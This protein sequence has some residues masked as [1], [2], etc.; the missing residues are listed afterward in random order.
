MKLAVIPARGGSKRIPAKNIRSFCGRPVIAYSIAAAAACGL[1]D[2]IVVSTDDERIAAVA[3]RHGAEVP[4]LRPKELAD[5]TTGTN[6]VVKHAIS[7]FAAGGH[8]VTHACCIYATAPFLQA[9]QLLAGFD[10][11]TASGKAFAFSVAL[12]PHPIQRAL[13]V[14]ADGTLGAFYPEH[15]F[16]RSQDLEPAYHDAGQFYWGTSEA[17]LGDKLMFS[18]D[19]VP[20]ILPRHVVADID[21]LEDWQEA[22]IKFKVLLSE[23]F[24]QKQ[25]EGQP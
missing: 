12:Y 14:S 2:R 23:P 21:T 13:R 16:T 18:P 24:R 10:K 4:F 5:D 22:E 17:F 7:W 1:F 15:A 19:A 20:V 3:R 8:P 6:A 9:R 25:E 11:L